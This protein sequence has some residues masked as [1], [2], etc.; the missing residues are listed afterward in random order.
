MGERPHILPPPSFLVFPPLF[1]ALPL[2][3][4]LNLSFHP[5]Q[6]E[7]GCF[8]ASRVEVRPQEGP[9][10]LG[11]GRNAVQLGEGAPESSLGAA[12]RG[13]DTAS[14]VSPPTPGAGG[15]GWG[16][17]GGGAADRLSIFGSLWEARTMGPFL[18]LHRRQFPGAGTKAPVRSGPCV[19]VGGGGGMVRWGV[20]QS[21][22]GDCWGP[23]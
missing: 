19:G 8:V 13:S 20:G 18:S 5:S 9:G 10:Y 17:W 21:R 23:W 15:G 1:P 22:L 14:R 2:A 7:G 3:L 11:E 4:P 12:I 16:G 6:E